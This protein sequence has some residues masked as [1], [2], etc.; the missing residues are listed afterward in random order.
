M[1]RKK[2]TAKAPPVKPEV[3]PGS[4]SHLEIASLA[5]VAPADNA[6]L[7]AHIK[8]LE[9]KLAVATAKRS[10]EDL[11][12]LASIQGIANLA[13]ERSREVPTGRTVT[14]KRLK[15]YR[16]AGFKDDGRD[17]LRPVFKDVQLPT[18]FYRIDLPPCGGSDVKINGMPLYHNA[19]VEVDI[20]TL[21]TLKSLV[22]NCWDHDRQIHGSD[23]NAYRKANRDINPANRLS[24]RMTG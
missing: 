15:N 11:A 1:P 7:H 20:D 4:T 10:E 21:R 12:L 17:I 24:M 2:G 16:V 13:G 18:F 19:T 14:V 6:A 3:D 23:E 8:D 22:F 9:A 5:G